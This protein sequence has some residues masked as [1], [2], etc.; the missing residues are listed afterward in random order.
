MAALT[1]TNV[2]ANRYEPGREYTALGSYTLAG[3]IASAD[4]ITWT[5]LLPINGVQILEFRLYGQEL[6]TNAT[7]TA[8]VIV[9]DATTTNGYLTSKTAGDANGQYQMFGDGAFIGLSTGATNATA[10]R[11][12]L[13]TVG[14]T[15]ATAASTG[16]VYVMVRYYCSGT[17]A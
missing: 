2:V 1:G 12:V 15:V 16:T 13:L 6:D 14:G 7:P 3:A 9:G 17:D 4:T 11:N 8:T 5:N 10:T